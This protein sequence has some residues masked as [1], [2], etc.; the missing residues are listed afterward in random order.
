MTKYKVLAVAV[1]T[2]V[3]LIAIYA[4]TMKLAVTNGISPIPLLIASILIFLIVSKTVKK[5]S[6]DAYE[7][8][9]SILSLTIMASAYLSTFLPFYF[10]LAVIS[11]AIGVSYK[12]LAY[13]TRK[14]ALKN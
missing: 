2:F 11:V 12:H 4:D 3:V 8:K 14:A 6:I 9:I 10:T 7:D 1:C 13:S 5:K